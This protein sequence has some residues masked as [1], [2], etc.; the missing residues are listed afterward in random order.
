MRIITFL[1]ALFLGV[2]TA[3]FFK[4]SEA[5]PCQNSFNSESSLSKVSGKSSTY[6]L[7]G[8]HNIDTSRNYTFEE[9]VA[10]VGKEVRNQSS[11]NA[12]CPKAYGNC[13]ELF[14]GETGEVIDILPSV[15]DSYLIEIK[16]NSKYTEPKDSFVTYAG[17]ELSFEVVD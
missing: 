17:K 12:K 11:S 15:N 2:Y 10:L 1:L 5:A 6:S 14:A 7:K 8:L 3:S 13:L 16:W 4:S 9:A